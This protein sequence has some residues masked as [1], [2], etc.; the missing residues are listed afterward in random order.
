MKL[1]SILVV[2]TL[3]SSFAYGADLGFKGGNNFQTINLSGSGRIYCP[4]SGESRFIRCDFQYLVPGER[5]YFAYGEEIDADRVKL[6]AIREDGSTRSKDSKY[7]SSKGRSSKSFNLWIRTL[8]QRPLLKMGVNTIAVEMT[9]DGSIVA[10]DEFV[11]TVEQ[12]ESRQCSYRSVYGRFDSDCE[13][14]YRACDRYF[15]AQNYCRQ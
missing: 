10:E 12:G 13:S 5:A 4:G 9:K 1:L 14:I 8:F 6:T 7:R 15:A 3:L 11:A 2:T